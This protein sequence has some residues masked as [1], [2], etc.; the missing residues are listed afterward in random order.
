MSK[1]IFIVK[2]NAGLLPADAEA[3]EVVTR[4]K[5]G[6]SISL[7]YAPARNPKF[8]RMIFAIAQT[9]VTN[10]PEGS[11]WSGKDA[12]HFI[13]AVELTIGMTEE[14]MDC[15][16]QVH[17]QAKS[18][19]FEN[20]DDEEFKTLFDPLVKEGARVLEIT[21]GELLDQLAGA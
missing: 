20:M 6:H 11:Y 21:E 14:I 15:N 7:T 2:T 9:V 4:W 19:A 12:K 1:K 13:K 10:A 8:H 5:V 17:L 16:G 3:E 18:I